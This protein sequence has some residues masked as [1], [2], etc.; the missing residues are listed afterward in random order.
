MSKELYSTPGA[1]CID[2][3]S[4][5]NEV[6][7][8]SDLALK[9]NINNPDFT[10]TVRLPV[11]TLAT[12]PQPPDFVGHVAY[13]TDTVHGGSPVYSDGT[14]WIELKMGSNL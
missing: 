5:G 2:G 8:K 3:L 13:V 7:R 1:A 10:G 14:H 9:A 6:A 12:L 4:D 11:Y